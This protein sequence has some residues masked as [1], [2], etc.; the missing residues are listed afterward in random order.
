MWSLLFHVLSN[1]IQAEIVLSRLDLILKGYV[2][3]A[4]QVGVVL[5]CVSLLY[6]FNHMISCC[7]VIVDL[8]LAGLDWTLNIRV[9]AV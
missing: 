1:Y 5:G 6:S 4:V 2:F 3:A 9:A 7:F 8:K